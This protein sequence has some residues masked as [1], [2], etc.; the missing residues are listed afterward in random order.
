MLTVQG[1]KN[2]VLAVSWSP[3]GCTVASA[4]MDGVIWLWHSSDGS[5]LGC[6]RGGCCIPCTDEMCSGLQ[7]H[8]MVDA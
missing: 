7:Q 2:W 3:D 5:P 1:H 8:Y 6:C 4:D